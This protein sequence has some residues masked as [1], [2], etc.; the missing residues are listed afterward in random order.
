MRILGFS[1]GP[2]AVH[3][4]TFEVFPGGLHDAA[5]VL[6]ADG[7]VVAAIEQ[8]RLDRIKHSNKRPF[9]AIRFCL[10][11]AGIGLGE[12]D[13]LAFYGEREYWDR[14]LAEH[15][16]R[17]PEQ[18]V[19]IDVRTLLARML[20]RD[21]GGPV[22][23]GQP[24]FVGHH[25]AHATSAVALSGFAESLVLVVDAQ[26]DDIS[27]LVLRAE[28]TELTVLRRLPLAKS[29]GYFYL[30]AI[31]YLGYRIFDE[32]KVMGLAP[33]GDAARFREIFRSLY[34]LEPEGEYSLDKEA[35]PR[36]LAAG[37]PRRPDAPIE[38][39]HQDLAAGLQ[40]ALETIVF[41]LLRYFR[42]TTGLRNLCLAGG[43]AHNCTLNGKILYSQMFDQVFV[44][45]AS[46]DAGC[47]LG[48]ALTLHHQNGG[49][50][51]T[52]RLAH[53]YW[54]SPIGDTVEVEARLRPWE[55]L[56]EIERLSDPA[57]TA[58]ELLAAGEVLG[59]AQGRSEFGPR[60]LGNR[61]IVADPRPARN[62]DLINAMVKKREAFRPFA[63]AVVEERAAEF[64]ELAPGVERL[65]FMVFT[66]RVR[67][68]KR[69]LLG[70]ITHVDGTARV[71]TVD[72]ATNEPFWLLLSRFGELTGVPIVLNTSFN[73][74]AEPIVDSVED[75]LVCYLTTHLHALVVG[76]FL[77]RRRAAGWRDH[78]LLVPSLPPFVELRRT[79]SFAPETGWGDR[80]ECIRNTT[81]RGPKISPELFHLLSRADGATALADLALAA[82]TP[83]HGPEAL[84]TELLALWSSR[85]VRLRPGSAPA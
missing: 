48:A 67:P 43:V 3:E 70:A 27:G 1:G 59:W 40:E 13:Q 14:M 11:S 33:Y 45:P 61:S 66:V 75:A 26:G 23:D 37:P 28:G 53:V 84:V 39:V 10:D 4:K 17:H 18:E 78:L 46:H 2:N 80:W 6:L 29:L 15:Y 24:H 47:A 60:A 41:H 44:Q 65:P 73:N 79:R 62:K 55:R 56:V 71:Q 58:A 76:D 22:R 63:P 64:F 8:E 49:P 35:L 51:T 31:E 34:T 82:A 77:V 68:E 36:L 81:S 20:E 12:V 69:E 38:Q 85:L 16:L 42:E 52:R 50:R 21:L 83:G 54:G 5:A 9:D 74:N 19:F 32:Y 25:L 72:R 30:G 7:E 57:A